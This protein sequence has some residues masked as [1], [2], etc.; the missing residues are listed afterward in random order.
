MGDDSIEEGDFMDT[1]GFADRNMGSKVCR[2]WTGVSAAVK[3]NLRDWLEW[4]PPQM[5]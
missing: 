1:W 4:N 3:E 2:D 5:P